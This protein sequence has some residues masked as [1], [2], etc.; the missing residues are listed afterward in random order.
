MP[1]LTVWT[2]DACH[3]GARTRHLFRA[4]IHRYAPRFRGGALAIYRRCRRRGGCLYGGVVATRAGSSVPDARVAV[5]LFGTGP[6][7]PSVIVTDMRRHRLRP[8]SR[9]TASPARFTTYLPM[10][11]LP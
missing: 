7:L 2:A 6:I 1:G 5:N 11:C 3:G 4:Y 10:T 8:A 9:L